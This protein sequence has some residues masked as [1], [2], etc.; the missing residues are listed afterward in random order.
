MMIETGHYSP[1]LYLAVYVFNWESNKIKKCVQIKN[2][3]QNKTTTTNN[4]KCGDRT[5]THR[6]D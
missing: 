3:L 6:N 2:L 1:K 5:L 4:Q